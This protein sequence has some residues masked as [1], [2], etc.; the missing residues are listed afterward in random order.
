MTITC[1]VRHPIDPFP[2]EAFPACAQTWC[3]REQARRGAP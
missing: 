2:H 3:T 1:F